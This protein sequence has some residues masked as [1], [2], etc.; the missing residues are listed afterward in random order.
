MSRRFAAYWGLALLACPLLA[1]CGDDAPLSPVRLSA[2]PLAPRRAP[3]AAPR[4]IAATAL[5]AAQ[6]PDA[7]EAP[8]GLLSGTGQDA[9]ASATVPLN[10]PAG[11]PLTPPADTADALTQ[12]SDTLAGSM[13][14]QHMPTQHSHWLRGSIFNARVQV[15]VNGLFL[16]TFTSPQDRDITMKLRGGINTMTLAYTPLTSTASA[17][18]DILE[19]EHDPPIPPLATFRSPLSSPTPR[20]PLQTTTQALTFLAR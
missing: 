13:P 19:S 15:R 3:P 5:P 8:D 7:L 1:G 16:G 6:P 14:G 12:S 18:L 17:H 9:A 4:S 2:A 11:P 20:A 10:T